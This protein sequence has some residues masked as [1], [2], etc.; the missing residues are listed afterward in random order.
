ME[1]GDQPP[2]GP[3]PGGPAPSA[4]GPDPQ[5]GPG[6]PAQP[7]AAAPGVGMRVEG[8]HAPRTFTKRVH[9]RSFAGS[10][11]VHALLFA[12]MAW[13]TGLGPTKRPPAPP[14]PVTLLSPLPQ[15]T[16]KPR[17]KARGDLA[18]RATPAPTPSPTPTPKPSPSPTAR[19]TPKP[20]AKPTPRPTPKPTPRPTPKPTPTGKPTPTPAERKTFEQMRK[21]PYFSKMSEEQLRKQPIPPGFKDWGQVEEMGRKLDGLQWLFL[22]P[23]TGEQPAASAPPATAAPSAAPATPRPATPRPG[24]PAPGASGSP[25]PLPSPEIEKTDGGV[26]VM[27]FQVETTPKATAFTVTWGDEQPDG[28]AKAVVEFKPVDAPEDQ[29][30]RTFEVKVDKDQQKFLQEILAGWAKALEESPPPTPGP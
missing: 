14:I 29:P 24:T 21:I 25:S 2:T 22:P 11:G 15:T 3:L 20:S 12:L 7:P 17:P 13:S 1:P 26:N 5:P 9:G 16:P 8:R 19:P 28:E 6:T 10:F 30:G 4:P 27:R 23:E 18:T